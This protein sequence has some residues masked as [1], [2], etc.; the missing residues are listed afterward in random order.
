MPKILEDFLW[1]AALATWLMLLCGFIISALRPLAK[2]FR[3]QI[4]VKLKSR[5][6]RS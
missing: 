5:V 1:C 2:A 4:E 3:Q 6:K